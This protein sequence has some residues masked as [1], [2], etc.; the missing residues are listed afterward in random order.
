[1]LM[2]PPKGLF[3]RTHASLSITLL[4]LA[5]VSSAVCSSTVLLAQFQPPA[6]EE[7]KMTSDPK[8]PG[9][10]AV[11][12]YREETT[13]DA[14]HFHSYYERIKIL[15][16]KGKELATISIPYERGPFKVTDIK[17]RTIHADGTI[18]PLTA[19]PADLVDEKSSARQ[20]NS[21]VFTLPAP[22]SAASSNTGCKSATT[23]TWLSSPIGKFSSLISFTKPT[24]SLIRPAPP[25][26]A[27]SP[28]AAGRYSIA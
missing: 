24:I 21:M 9:A 23:T 26:R 13:D 28:T 7:L 11:Y 3:M 27:Q 14:L 2:F 5:A 20:V 19:K 4:S 8:A 1:M 15:T 6:P 12:L 22:R 16:E 18:V 10:D 25:S 17:G